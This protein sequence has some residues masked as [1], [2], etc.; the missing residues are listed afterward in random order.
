MLPLLPGELGTDF[1]LDRILR[2]GKVA[3]VAQSDE[4]EEG[5]I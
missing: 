3:V 5:R 2:F 1:D 4:V